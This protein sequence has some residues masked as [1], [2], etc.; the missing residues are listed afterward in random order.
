VDT[1]TIEAI[2]EAHRGDPAATLLLECNKERAPGYSA[3]QK[4]AE[5]LLKI[6]PEQPMPVVISGALGAACSRVLPANDKPGR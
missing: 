2:D 3:V 5:D 6:D 4:I 1:L